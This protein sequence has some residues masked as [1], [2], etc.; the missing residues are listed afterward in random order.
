MSYVRY[1]LDN[2]ALGKE[3]N[4]A[5]LDTVVLIERNRLINKIASDG[6]W[7]VSIPRT[8]S[9]AVQKRL[10]DTF[11]YP[12]GKH[13]FKE[14]LTG[15]TVSALL[16]AHTPSFVARDIIGDSLWGNTNTFTIVRH[17]YTWSLSLWKYTKKYGP[18]G[19]SDGD[20]LTFLAEFERNTSLPRTN[21]PFTPS[22]FMQHDYV[23]E[24]DGKR[25]IVK[26]VLRFEDRPKIEA[27]L[28]NLNIDTSDF[29]KKLRDTDSEEYKL[30]RA[31]K[32]EIR[33]VLAKD[34]DFLNC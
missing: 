2:L 3:Y 14:P 25:P 21:R 7:F 24:S 17:P 23:I 32:N 19:F 8:S 33:R 30:T 20:F 6:F 29:D 4:I 16:P 18:L 22:H 26:N 12:H 31:E 15:F 11:G 27:F 1:C 13:S 34:F 5:Q 9:S 28:K 10:S